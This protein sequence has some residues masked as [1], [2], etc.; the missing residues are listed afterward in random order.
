MFKSS[1]ICGGGL[2]GLLMLGS[3]AAGCRDQEPASIEIS[4]ST[5]ESS[6]A[7]HLQNWNWEVYPA[8]QRMR[9]A[10]LPCQLMP[11][12]SISIYSPMLGVLRVYATQPQTNLP[13]GLVWAEFEPAI[14][15]AES[16]ALDEARAKLEERERLQLELELPKQKLRFEKE[17]DEAQR[18]VALLSLLSTNEE[19]ARLSLKLPNAGGLGPEALGKAQIELDLLLKSLGYLQSTNLAF[20]GIDLPGQRSEWERRKLEFDRRQSQARLKMPFDG[21]LTINLPLTEGV[22][23]YP[24]NSGQELA[25]ARDLSMIRLRVALSN[26]AWA[27]L[28]A[29]RLMALIRMPSGE[30]LIATFA[31]QKIERVQLREES[32]YYFQFA[33]EKS[34]LAARL[35]GTDVSC[36]LWVTLPQPAR[37]VPKLALV[38]QQPAAFQGRNWS[39]GVAAMWPGAHVLVEGQTDLAVVLVNSAK[40]K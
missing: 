6:P 11:R 9:L 25:V 29:D 35:M 28:P 17:V 18:Q 38:L 20:L 27:G 16:E 30:E 13:S 12:S 5:S 40:V 10:V 4:R 34:A 22:D 26:P 39:Q 24:V 31:F 37:V 23:E 8:V 7:T 21:Q 32:V 36:E 1:Q 14:F 3:F 33:P 2:A 15:A 19:L